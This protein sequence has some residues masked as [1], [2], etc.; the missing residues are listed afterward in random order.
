M[1]V[2]IDLRHVDNSV[3]LETSDTVYV[4]TV[5][6][7]VAELSTLRQSEWPA[8]VTTYAAAKASP[9]SAPAP[10][11]IFE[12]S[13]ADA[14]AFEETLAGL[15]VLLAHIALNRD[16]LA[17]AYAEREAAN[18]ERARLAA[19]NPP[20][21]RNQTIYFWKLAAPPAR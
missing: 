7:A 2:P 17:A 10:D 19:L 20:R 18:A 3:V 12:G 11:Y 9:D 16:A 15:D 6:V 21:P 5:L 4:Y 13:A 8:E 1:F 14:E